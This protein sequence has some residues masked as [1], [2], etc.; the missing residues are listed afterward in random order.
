MTATTNAAVSR[1]ERRKLRTRSALIGAAQRFLAEGRVT[2]SVLD[3]TN[4]ADVGM[5]SFYNH[6]DS[7]EDLY[8]AAVDAALE[9]H[10]ALMDRI[11]HDMPDPAEAFTQSFRLTGRMHRLNP[12]ISR[13]LLQRGSSMLLADE[14]LAPRARRDLI[15]AAEAGRFAIDDIDT[16][17]VAVAGAAVALGELLHSQPDRDAGTTSDA[18]TQRVLMSL[19]MSADD[20]AALCRIPLPDIGSADLL[21]DGA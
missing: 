18:V 19:G 16:A 4:A 8:Q 17:M 7:K 10:G 5:G 15:A 13:V 9:A 20:A 6:F 21:T 11:T 14:G 1:S 3:L 12:E 2:A